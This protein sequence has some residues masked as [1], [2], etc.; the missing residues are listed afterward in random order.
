MKTYNQKYFRV[1]KML[2]SWLWPVTREGCCKWNKDKVIEKA[3]PLGGSWEAR[4]WAS[5]G[6]SWP[7]SVRTPVHLWAWWL[8]VL[9]WLWLNKRKTADF[10]ESWVEA[11]LS[12]D[13]QEPVKMATMWKG[14]G[15]RA[16]YTKRPHQ[17]FSR[18]NH[19]HSEADFC[20]TF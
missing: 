14:R 3:Q 5:G 13:A 7:W 6:H 8:W 4:N 9:V 10:Q 17:N 15:A 2:M 19:V 12:L 16:A 20:L 18:T 11:D 1:K